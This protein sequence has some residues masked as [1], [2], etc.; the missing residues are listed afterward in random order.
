MPGNMWEEG[1]LTVDIVQSSHPWKSSWSFIFED[2]MMFN[3]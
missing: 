1:Y 3:F 2:A